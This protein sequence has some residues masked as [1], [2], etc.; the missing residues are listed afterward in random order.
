[1]DRRLPLPVLTGYIRRVAVML[2]I[3]QLGKL[4]GLSISGGEP[5]PQLWQIIREFGDLSG[6]TAVVAV[7]ALAALLLLRFF[8]PKL[9][10]ALL[11]VAAEA[12]VPAGGDQQRHPTPFSATDGQNSAVSVR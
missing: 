7:V 2:I 6:A 1:M 8:L 5:L 4:L 12:A 10:G 9:P 3:S 11:A